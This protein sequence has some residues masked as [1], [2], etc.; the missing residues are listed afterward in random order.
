V[1]FG[2]DTGHLDDAVVGMPAIASTCY[3]YPFH[4]PHPTHIS[5][6]STCIP[7][8]I[9]QGLVPCPSPAASNPSYPCFCPNDPAPSGEFT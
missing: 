4:L 3:A 9:P 1:P 2:K 8:C 6:T 7:T 5:R